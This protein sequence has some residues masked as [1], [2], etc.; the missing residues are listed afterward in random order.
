MNQFYCALKNKYKYRN[1]AVQNL[2][3]KIKMDELKGFS[4]SIVFLLYFK[5]IWGVFCISVCALSLDLDHRATTR[6]S[7]GM[8]RIS[9]D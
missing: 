8:T 3:G 1:E 6:F 4:A 9:Q 5:T 7:I 2:L